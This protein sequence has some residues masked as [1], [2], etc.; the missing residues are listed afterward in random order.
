MAACASVSRV[1]AAC[2]PYAVF[3]ASDLA[4]TCAWAA[5]PCTPPFAP[6]STPLSTPPS[7]PPPAAGPP[8]VAPPQA[9]RPYR[10]RH[11]RGAAAVIQGELFALPSR[12]AQGS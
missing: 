7:T 5:P 4:R 9:P 3:R 10:P 12:L 2:S 11:R 8:V 1:V 6:P